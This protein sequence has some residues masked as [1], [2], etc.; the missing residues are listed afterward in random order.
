MLRITL[1]SCAAVLKY[2][3]KHNRYAA[4]DVSVEEY[5]PENDSAKRESKFRVKC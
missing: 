5:Q 3:S 4:M 1:S 2:G